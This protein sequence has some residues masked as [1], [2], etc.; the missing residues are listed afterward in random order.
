MIALCMS[1][2]VEGI[3]ALMAPELIRPIKRTPGRIM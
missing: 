3:P 1:L 2:L